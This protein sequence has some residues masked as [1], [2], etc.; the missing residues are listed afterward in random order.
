[1]LFRRR[2]PQPHGRARNDLVRRSA[3]ALRMAQD[4][5]GVL[6]STPHR[7]SCRERQA[8]LIQCIRTPLAFAP[9]T[10][11]STLAGRASAIRPSSAFHDLSINLNGLLGQ[12]GAEGWHFSS[13]EVVWYDE[14]PVE[15][16][17]QI[18]KTG[19]C[20]RP[21]VDGCALNVGRGQASR[22]KLATGADREPVRST[23]TTTHQATGHWMAAGVSCP[24]M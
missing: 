15:I 10:F 18:E 12:I 13:P 2:C 14:F 20:R 22:S 6:A 16:R 23:T 9:A 17:I 8:T 4:M 5:S 21:H 1:M 3:Q 24:A 7:R 19:A 11:G